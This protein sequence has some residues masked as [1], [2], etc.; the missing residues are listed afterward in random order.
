MK[1]RN[2]LLINILLYLALC[3]F[4]FLIFTRTNHIS[5]R[6][7]LTTKR[8]VF[9]EAVSFGIPAIL[10]V[11]CAIPL[12]K[13]GKKKSTKVDFTVIGVLLT[14]LF[15]L[16]GVFFYGLAKDWSKYSP[17]VKEY[18]LPIYGNG[19]LLL[20]VFYAIV[21]AVRYV[22]TCVFKA[23]SEAAY[24]K[25]SKDL[26]LSLIFVG[27]VASLLGVR[28]FLFMLGNKTYDAF[29][30]VPNKFELIYRIFVICYAACGIILAYVKPTHVV[31]L[32]FHAASVVVGLIIYFIFRGVDY[33]IYGKLCLISAGCSA[34]AVY[35]II[36]GSYVVKPFIEFI[37]SCNAPEDKVTDEVTEEVAEETDYATSEEVKA[38]EEKV[39]KL[40]NAEDEETKKYIYT[41][42]DDNKILRARLEK[43]EERLA[44][45]EANG[46]KTLKAEPHYETETVTVVRKGFKSRLVNTPNEGLKT[47]YQNIANLCN[48]YKKV[49]IR[50]SFAK[51]TI[52]VGRNNV[53][54]LK[55]STSGKAMYMYMALDKSYLEQT[56]YH[57]KDYSEKKSYVN[58]PLR[59]RV[60]SNR[61]MQYALELLAVVLDNN[62]EKYVKDREDIDLSKQLKSQS[63][64]EML[65]NGLI[66]QHYV[67]NTYLVEPV[68]EDEPE[69][70]EENDEDDED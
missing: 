47:T 27:L 44:L 37:T 13:L 18:A 2:L 19:L 11:A 10:S 3:V 60:C 7:L 6:G 66:K 70:D 12:G 21:F 30:E 67:E 49:K 16:L 58:T 53:C 43:V 41:L 14:V 40:E 35:V 17:L 59:L 61:S 9:G 36:C 65:K 45:L 55:M 1:K 34:I 52:H 4:G 63:E 33:Q 29:G 32:I 48:K 31:N 50:E 57:L 64:A 68:Y 51:E 38:L 56:K 39:E 62:A 22:H 28:L 23:D 26:F 5:I 42:E 69:T 54:I 25:H 46:V 24:E 8:F 20:F 15:A